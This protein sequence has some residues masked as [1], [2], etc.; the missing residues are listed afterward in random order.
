MTS[1]PA[2][3]TRRPSLR[4]EKSLLREHAVLVAGCDEVGRGA[5]AGPV[6]VGVV[7]VD[8]DVRR[9]PAGLTDSK[10]LSPARRERLVPAIRRWC[11]ASAVGHATPGEIDAFGLTQALRL[12]GLRALDGLRAAG[13]VGR[14]DVVLL[15]GSFDWL[16]V[17]PRTEAEPGLWEIE[18]PPE[19]VWPEVAP[20]PVVTQVKA[21]L[22]CASVAAA[23]VLAKTTRDG[24]MRDLAQQ[25]P[26]F[27]WDENKGYASDQHRAALHVH[28]PCEHHRQTWRLM[29]DVEEPAQ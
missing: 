26:H 19:P 1:R 20:P 29:G 4:R 8:A 9:V 24:L 3:T 14:P 2:V 25:H 6:T 23:S 10:L 27:G 15:D 7:V 22:T 5:L 13:D 18:A 17:R 12:A 11:R 16:T 21:D 28:G